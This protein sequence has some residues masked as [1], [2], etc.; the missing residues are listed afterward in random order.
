M[1][2]YQD[3]DIFL[4]KFFLRLSFLYEIKQYSGANEKLDC[5]NQ[6]KMRTYFEEIIT[7]FKRL[8]LWY[9]IYFN[10]VLLF[11]VHGKHLRPCRDGQLT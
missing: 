7:I 11:Y 8:S 9:E 2:T 3:L 1:K 6:H 10:V 5:P 4:E